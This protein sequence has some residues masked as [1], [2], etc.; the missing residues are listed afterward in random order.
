MG[1]SLYH[2]ISLAQ[3]DDMAKDYGDYEGLTSKEILSKHPDWSIW[4]QGECSFDNSL[5]NVR[6]IRFILQAALEERVS[7]T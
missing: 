3:A 5:Q 4:T 1:R 2:A 6:L 7:K